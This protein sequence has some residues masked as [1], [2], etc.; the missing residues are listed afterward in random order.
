MSSPLDP[1]R[2]LNVRR[3]ARRDEIR[4]AYR[5][6]AW[7]W[8]PDR[9]GAAEQ[10]IQINQAWR[11]LGHAARRAAYDAAVL[12]RSTAPTPTPTAPEAPDAAPTRPLSQRVAEPG[13]I[14]YGRYAGWSIADL[15]NHDP[16]FLEWLVRMPAGRHHSTQI[17]EA[18]SRR[19]RQVAELTP[20]ASPPDGR[21]SG[22]ERPVR[23]DRHDGGAR[24]APPSP[25]AR[26]VCKVRRKV[27][28]G[29]CRHD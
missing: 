19:E 3:D 11:T 8:H 9:G 23:R 18:L 25:S 21:C 17:R 7:R 5:S 6:L 14:D 13:I 22:F 26:S 20:T 4:A 1:Y 2:V 24:A 16:N 28:F 12:Q 10:M 27:P 29:H 15:A